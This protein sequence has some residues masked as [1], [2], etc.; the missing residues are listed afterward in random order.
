MTEWVEEKYLT[1]KEI[2]P[3]V[4]RET[5]ASLMVFEEAVKKW[6]SHINLI[7]NATLPELWTRHILD[8]AQ[9][10]ALQPQ[11]KNWCDIGSGGGFP[12]IVTAILLKEQSGFHIDLVES[13]SKKAAFLR[14]VSAE[15]NLPA[16]VHTCRIEN[17]YIHIKKPEII[18]SRALASLEK[19]F[20][21]TQPWF[22]Q[23]ATALFQK[24]RDYK[25]EI[26]EAEKNW[27]FDFEVHQSKIDEHSV[28]LEISKIDSRKG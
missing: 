22:E 9:I 12:G 21:L 6:Q 14:S 19:L 11:A 3:S 4:S 26:A 5:A 25:K 13:N 24:G 20:E 16:T 8:S 15:F 2:V 7:A 28:I 17:S 18:T 27:K 10:A 1:L 23:G